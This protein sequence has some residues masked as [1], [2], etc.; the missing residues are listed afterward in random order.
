VLRSHVRA[1]GR[2]VTIRICQ[3]WRELSAHKAGPYQYATNASLRL[4]G[5]DLLAPFASLLPHRWTSRGR[6]RGVG[7]TCTAPNYTWTSRTHDSSGVRQ[8]LRG[9]NAASSPFRQ[10]GDSRLAATGRSGF[11][12]QI[13]GI[14][15][16]RENYAST[17]RSALTRRVFRG[18]GDRQAPMFRQGSEGGIRRRMRG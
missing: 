18:P 1:P 12:Q 13:D 14:G 15:W 10:N 16:P 17:L 3:M 2:A 11:R 6:M 8:D 7:T 5:R 9:M 4:D